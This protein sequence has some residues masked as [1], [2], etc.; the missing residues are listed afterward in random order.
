VYQSYGRIFDSIYAH[1]APVEVVNECI[2]SFLMTE[3]ISI[4]TEP[5]GERSDYHM[6]RAQWNT[7]LTGVLGPEFSPRCDSAC[8]THEYMSLFTLHYGRTGESGR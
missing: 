2:D 1:D 6:Q 7:L 5:R 3:V 4:L 8:Y